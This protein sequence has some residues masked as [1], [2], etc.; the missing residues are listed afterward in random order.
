MEHLVVST[1]ETVDEFRV[2]SPVAS[3]RVPSRR[4]G[5][6]DGPLVHGGELTS[7]PNTFSGGVSPYK[8]VG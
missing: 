4:I 2:H 5:R 7:M 1:H 3:L 8:I 6:L